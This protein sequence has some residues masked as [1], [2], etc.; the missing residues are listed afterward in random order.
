MVKVCGN[1][2][3]SLLPLRLVSLSP[4]R[5][6]QALCSST[7]SFAG[8]HLSPLSLSPGAQPDPTAA[9]FPSALGDMWAVL[10]HLTV[11]QH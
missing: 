11:S 9:P 10:R 7:P 4:W 5:T 2:L 6:H 8:P 3:M 1:C